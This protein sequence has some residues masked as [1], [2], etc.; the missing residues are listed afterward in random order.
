MTPP[1]H[2]RNTSSENLGRHNRWL[3]GQ[4]KGV[5]SDLFGE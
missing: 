3:E 1:W 2:P 5:R 4:I